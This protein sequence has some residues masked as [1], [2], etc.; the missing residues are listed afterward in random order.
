MVF[1]GDRPCSVV[2]VVAMWGCRML[3]KCVVSGCLFFTVRMEYADRVGS[4]R[5][6]R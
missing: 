6:F 1:V 5:S 4:V 2:S 3:R